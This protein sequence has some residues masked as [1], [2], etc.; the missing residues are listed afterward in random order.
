[1]KSKLIGGILLIV[2]TSIGAG[3]LALPVATAPG[4]FLGAA[5]LLLACWLLM[6]FSALV[7]LEVN[8]WLPPDSN[9]VSMAQK[10]AGR[11]AEVL[12]WVV[13]LLLL[14]SLISAYIS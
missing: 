10:T 6:T 2:G 14:Y 4:G 7:I 3:M 12:A 5:I 11:F 13:Y 1:M 9:I 8:L